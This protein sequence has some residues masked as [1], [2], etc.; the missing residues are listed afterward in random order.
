MLWRLWT[1]TKTRKSVTN[2]K[3]IAREIRLWKLSESDIDL[4][5]ERKLKAAVWRKRDSSRNEMYE[6]MAHEQTPYFLEKMEQIFSMTKFL[7][8]S[9]KFFSRPQ[10][11]L[12][13]FSGCSNFISVESNPIKII[14]SWS[15]NFQKAMKPVWKCCMKSKWFLKSWEAGW[16]KFS[17]Y[18]FNSRCMFFINN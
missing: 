8:Y 11:F 6:S 7:P 5:F 18:S 9:I 16:E 4:S 10:I 12:V 3:L 2:L 15:C 1:E 17:S 14:L 13:T